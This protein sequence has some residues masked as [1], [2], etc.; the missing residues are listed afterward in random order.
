M[1]FPKI[2]IKSLQIVHR[3]SIEC[4]TIDFTSLDCFDGLPIY[5]FGKSSLSLSKSTIGRPFKVHSLPPTL[6]DLV[7]LAFV[8]NWICLRIYLRGFGLAQ[9]QTKGFGRSFLM[10]ICLSTA[11]IV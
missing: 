8:W 9:V 6:V 3:L 1:E 2:P 10:R 5:F 7:L 11:L 4:G